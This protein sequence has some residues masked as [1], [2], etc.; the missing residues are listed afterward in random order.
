MY[1]SYLKGN[2]VVSCRATKEVYVPSGFELEEYC[3]SIRHKVCP[4]YVGRSPEPGLTIPL[5][6]GECCLCTGSR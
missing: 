6:D 4:F 2:Y 1:C 3:R 5:R